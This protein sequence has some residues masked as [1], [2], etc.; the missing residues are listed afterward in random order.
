MP[1]LTRFEE[2]LI[3]TLYRRVPQ[4]VDV[5]PYTAEMNWLA[6]EFQAV[7]GR[8]MT[9]GEVFR[10]LVGLRKAGRLDLKGKSGRTARHGLN[11]RSLGL[12]GEL[13]AA[14]PVVAD[15]L[16]YTP[17]FERMYAAF[18]ARSRQRTTRALFFCALLAERKAGR[19]PRKVAPKR[20]RVAPL[21][22]VQEP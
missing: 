21:G 22:P 9:A 16:P 19:L 6:G 18:H 3:C 15:R 13:Y 2:E 12:I 5:L 4:A 17:E 1:D 14:Q 8:E 7:S 20:A 11:R 10:A